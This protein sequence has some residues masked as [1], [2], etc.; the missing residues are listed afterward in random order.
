MNHDARMQ[1]GE[2]PPPTMSISLRVRVRVRAMVRVRVRVVVRVRV[3]VVVSHYLLEVDSSSLRRK[4]GH[5][6]QL[7]IPEE[8]FPY[9]VVGSE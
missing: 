2:Y 7:Q 9:L 8:C 6:Y 4:V 5:H 3:R 1:T